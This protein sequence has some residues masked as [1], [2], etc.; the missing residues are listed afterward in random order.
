MNLIGLPVMLEPREGIEEQ[1]GLVGCPPAALAELAD[2]VEPGEQGLAVEWDGTGRPMKQ[3][4]RHRSRMARLGSRGQ[5]RPVNWG[6]CSQLH[7]ERGSGVFRL[8]HAQIARAEP[9]T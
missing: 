7:R 6:R 4:V 3:R 1:Q 8:L 9:R 2:A 5:R